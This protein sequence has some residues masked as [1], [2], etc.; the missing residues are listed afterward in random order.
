M[1]FKRISS[2]LENVLD[3]ICDRIIKM[4]NIDMKDC[5]DDEDDYQLFD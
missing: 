4:D 2:V 5:Y 1:I 3:V